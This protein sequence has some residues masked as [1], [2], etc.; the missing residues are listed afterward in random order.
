MSTRGKASVTIRAEPDRL[1]AMVTDVTR[2]GEWS[3]ENY[4]AEWLDGGAGPAVGA[5]FKGYNR[6]RKV[7]WSTLCEVT[8]AAP[9]RVFAFTVGTA[10][11][12]QTLWRYQ[13]TPVADGVE[14]TETFELLKPLGIL[15]RLATRLTTGVHDRRAD[16]EDGARSTI[17]AIKLAAEA[18]T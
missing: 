9:P 5:R 15:S 8:E 13:L 3:P 2:M 1:W 6:R 4:R 12:P 16:L 14:L 7:K 10:A 11:K 17:N 18:S